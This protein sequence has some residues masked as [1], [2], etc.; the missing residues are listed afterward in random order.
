M[1]VKERDNQGGDYPFF[2]FLSKTESLESSNE[3]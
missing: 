2:H 1:R 3:C